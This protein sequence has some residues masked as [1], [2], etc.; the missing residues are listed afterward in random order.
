MQKPRVGQD[1]AFNAP[2]RLTTFQ[3]AAPAVGLVELITLP[4]W[5]TATQRSLLGHD[6]PSRTSEPF[7]WILVQP[8]GGVGLLVGDG[9][10]ACD[11]AGVANAVG[12]GLDSPVGVLMA[13]GD[14]AIDP[15]AVPHPERIKSAA[16]NTALM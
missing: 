2:P 3:A 14:G 5:S 9:V 11:V 10:G 4:A 7:T 1:T 16:R 6:T 13:L 12:D 15:V 8:A